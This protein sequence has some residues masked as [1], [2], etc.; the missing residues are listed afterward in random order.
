MAHLCITY[1]CISKRCC[2][3]SKIC[4]DSSSNQDVAWNDNKIYYKHNCKIICYQ[5]KLSVILLC[6][7][8]HECRTLFQPY[9]KVR[10]RLWR[11]CDFRVSFWS[12]CSEDLFGSWWVSHTIFLIRQLDRP[13]KFS[14]YKNFKNLLH[15]LSTFITYYAEKARFTEKGINV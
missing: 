6:I 3:W 10:R 8:N 5:Y 4:D 2:E 14:G 9:H 1:L 7:L 12:C 15:C 11:Q 13:W